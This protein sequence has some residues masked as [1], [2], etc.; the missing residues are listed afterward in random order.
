LFFAT[1]DALAD[2]IR[3]ITSSASPPKGI[4][5]DCGGL[6]F[7]DSQGSARLGEI[8]TSAEDAGI[9]FR[10]ARVKPAVRTVLINDG[11]W[12]RIGAHRVHSN[13]FQAVQAQLDP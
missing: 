4:V 5:L 10:L 2:R 8:I 1:S 7:I 3:A 13:I 12:D 9:T 6:D 11:V